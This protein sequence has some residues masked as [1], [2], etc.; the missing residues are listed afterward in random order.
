MMFGLDE[1]GKLLQLL[2]VLVVVVPVVG[3]AINSGQASH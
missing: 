1:E 2:E 3:G